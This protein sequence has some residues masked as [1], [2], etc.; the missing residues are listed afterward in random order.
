[1]Q[2]FRFGDLVQIGDVPRCM[3]HFESNCKAIILYSDISLGDIEKANGYQYSV[4]IKGYGKVAW[5]NE[6][7]LTFIKE[8]QDILLKEWIEEVKENK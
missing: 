2:K 7:L 5:Y 4:Y 1:M 8:K 3:S 6:E